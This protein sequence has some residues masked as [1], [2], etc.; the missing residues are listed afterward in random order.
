MGGRYRGKGVGCM[1]SADVVFGVYILECIALGVLSL[2]GREHGK[3][4]TAEYRLC[5]CRV[6]VYVYWSVS[7]H[8]EIKRCV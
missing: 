5:I 8:L 6:R 1:I 4:T 7:A 3:I 2:S